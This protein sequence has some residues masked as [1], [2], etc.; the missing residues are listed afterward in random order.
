[1]QM[2]LQI[3][4]FCSKY[5]HCVLVYKATVPRALVVYKLLLGVGDEEILNRNSRKRWASEPSPVLKVKMELVLGQNLKDRGP[6][7][8]R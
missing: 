2:E 8:R 1:M 5:T 7:M 6:E 3:Q 4:Q